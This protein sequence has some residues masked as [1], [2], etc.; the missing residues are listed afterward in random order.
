MKKSALPLLVVVLVLSL[1]VSLPAAVQ[2]WD[3]DGATVG[4]SI[5]GNWNTTTPNWTAS[6]DSGANAVWTQGNDASFGVTANYTVTLTEPMTLG[7]LTVTGN[8]GALTITG[9]SVNNV[10]FAGAASTFNIGGSRTN[11][12]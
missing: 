3:P 11:T 7:N 10:A 12:V 6:P 2:F 5:S 1:P 9:T 8:A 4:T